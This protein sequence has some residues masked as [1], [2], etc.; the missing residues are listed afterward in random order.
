VARV[1][2][3]K[4]SPAEEPEYRRVNE[5]IGEQTMEIE[6]LC[7]KIVDQHPYEAKTSAP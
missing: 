6:F 1:V 4:R 7:E 5:K 2:S 3:K